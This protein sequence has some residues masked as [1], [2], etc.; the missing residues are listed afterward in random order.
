MS[1]D[2]GTG[3]Y[4]ISSTVDGRPLNICRDPPGPREPVV[5]DRTPIAFIV[6][7]QKVD[8]PNCTYHISVRGFD[9][10]RYLR[11]VDGVL[12][13]S[14]DRMAPQEWVISPYSPGLYT[15]VEDSYPPNQAWTDSKGEEP[16]CN[17]PVLITTMPMI[18]RVDPKFV[19]RFQPVE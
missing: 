13:A 1:C 12:T 18:P 19:F 8:T 7:E 3:Q 17:R 2:L 10:R 9:V 14:D 11:N 15:I 4:F 5:V 16:G 6:V